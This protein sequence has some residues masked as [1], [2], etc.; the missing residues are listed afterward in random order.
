MIKTVRQTSLLES[1][2]L[3]S[4]YLDAVNAFGC[5]VQSNGVEG[6]RIF[7]NFIKITTLFENKKLTKNLL[8]DIFS[9]LLKDMRSLDP[10][11][12]EKVNRYSIIL[13]E[14]ISNDLDFFKHAA[15]NK[16]IIQ[17]VLQSSKLLDDPTIQLEYANALLNFHIRETEKVEY[18]L[19]KDL[20]QSPNIQN[21]DIEEMFS[22]DGKIKKGKKFVTQSRAIRECSRTFKL[23]NY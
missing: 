17:N 14:L 5:G 6:K 3:I 23:F 8:M 19:M 1:E 7:D 20:E 11:F 9:N 15:P 16:N 13:I 18:Y 10:T 4:K 21:Y 2:Q 22:I 12:S